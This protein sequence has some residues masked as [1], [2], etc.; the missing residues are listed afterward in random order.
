MFSTGM[1]EKFSNFRPSGT[2][3]S[4][5][6]EELNILIK[7]P[8]ILIHSRINM[9]VPHFTA[10]IQVMKKTTIRELEYFK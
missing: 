10:M 4:N 9:V 2:K 5:Q 8:L 1:V 7:T 3:L 6:S